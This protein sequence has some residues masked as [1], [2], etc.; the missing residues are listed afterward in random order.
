MASEKNPVPE[1]LKPYIF[2]KGNQAASKSEE[3]RK[4]EKVMI[5]FTKPEKERLEQLAS[6]SDLSLAEYIRN[7]VKIHISDTVDKT[8]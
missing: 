6:A 4:T 7:I 2:S 8:L 3:E 5:R 1:Q